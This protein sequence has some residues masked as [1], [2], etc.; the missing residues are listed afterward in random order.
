MSFLTIVIFGANVWF[1]NLRTHDVKGGQ[2]CLGILPTAGRCVAH[3]Q[4][5]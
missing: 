5:L 2:F 1:V 4:A 3:V